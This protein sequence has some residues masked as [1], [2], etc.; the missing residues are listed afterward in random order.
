MSATESEGPLDGGCPCGALRYRLQRTPMFTHCCHCTRCQRETG[1]PFAHHA[2]IEWTAFTVLQGEPL[3]ARVPSD[4]G[5]EHRVARCAKC[6]ST[7]WNEWGAPGRAVTRYVRVGTLDEPARCPP[8]AHIFTR[9]A[10]AW[11]ALPTDGA[12]RFKAWYKSAKLWPEASQA[13]FDEAKAALLAPWRHPAPAAEAP[14]APSPPVTASPA[15]TPR[16]PTRR[17]QPP[18][19]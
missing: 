8:Q 17:R 15:P 1:A 19:S 13:R 16:K 14:S 11:L 3:F 7:L 10:Q 9:S 4:S 5:G 6:H 12:P 18:S 2:L